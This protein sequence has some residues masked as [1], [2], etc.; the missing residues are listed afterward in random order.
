MP[1]HT[2][3]DTTYE[4]MVYWPKIDPNLFVVVELHLAPSFRYNANITRVPRRAD[5]RVG[6]T[7]IYPY[8]VCTY[9]CEKAGWT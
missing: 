2:E 8:F 4:L 6:L 7:V 5:N 3:K 1:S 9:Q